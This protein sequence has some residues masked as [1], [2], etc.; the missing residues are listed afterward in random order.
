[1]MPASP[2]R[3]FGNGGI[4]L[5][6][7][8]EAIWARS[9]WLIPSHSF[10]EHFGPFKLFETFFLETFFVV[11]LLEP[12]RALPVTM[13]SLTVYCTDNLLVIVLV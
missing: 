7:N 2:P 4:V 10:N 3:K 8:L 5:L 11:I 12:C 9:F 13:T 6:V 1:M